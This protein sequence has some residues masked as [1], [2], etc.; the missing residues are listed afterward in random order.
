MGRYAATAKA[1][2]TVPSS[3]R[4]QEEES[5]SR[6]K[7]EIKAKA[8]AH[9]EEKVMEESRRA[10]TSKVRG[11]EWQHLET[12]PIGTSGVK[13]NG[14]IRTEDMHHRSLHRPERQ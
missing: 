8:K 13:A 1:K 12:D 9:R 10:D 5:S 7:R 2:V 14:R 4:A 6:P 3:V 11:Q